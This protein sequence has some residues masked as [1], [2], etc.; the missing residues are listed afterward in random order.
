MTRFVPLALVALLLTGCTAIDYVPITAAPTTAGVVSTVNKDRLTG[1][2]ERIAVRAVTKG[3]DGKLKEVT[4]A[5]CRLV[6]DELRAEV[7]T[8]QEVIVPTFKQRIEFKDRGL[9]SALVVDCTA[10][11]QTGRGML[12][13]AQKEATMATGAGLAGALISI[14]VTSAIASA[15]PWAFPNAISVEVK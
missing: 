2:T 1:K 8:P 6:S 13:A 4:G 5:T 11:K 9:P 15:T 10:G 7:V 3:A 12:V 14:A